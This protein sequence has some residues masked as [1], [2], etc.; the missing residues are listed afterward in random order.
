MASVRA[1]ASPKTVDEREATDHRR[2]DRQRPDGAVRGEVLVVQHAEVFRHFL[3]L[4]HGVGDARAG[5]HAG[6]R[7]AD[8]RQEHRDGF[9]QHEGSAVARAEDG[10]AHHDHHVA[11]G[12]RRARGGLH[13]V[14]AIQEV[15]GREVLEQIAEGSLHQQRGDDRDGNVA[16]GVLGLA[17]HRGHRFESD[18][19]QNRDGGLHEHPAEVVHRR[20][21]M[22][23]S[24]GPENCGVPGVVISVY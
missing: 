12:R 4:A 17:A 15:V 18:Q 13:G 8:Q 6:E 5:V 9:D 1:P 16:L 7:G 20:P 10:V 23:R 21:R 2:N 11:D 19:D 3:V 22:W 24:D 14:A